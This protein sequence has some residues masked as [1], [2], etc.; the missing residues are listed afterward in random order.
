LVALAH[1]AR[2]LR[3]RED[4]IPTRR[5]LDLVLVADYFP[6]FDHLGAH[7]KQVIW[8]EPSVGGLFSSHE[9]GG[10]IKSLKLDPIDVAIAIRVAGSHGLHHFEHCLALGLVAFAHDRGE[11]GIGE[12]EIPASEA[13]DLSYSA[14]H[15]PHVDHFGAQLQEVRSLEVAP[16]CLLGREQ[17]VR[18]VKPLEFDPVNHAVS[19]RVQSPHGLHH[20][21]H[22]LALGLVAFAHDRGELGIGENEIPA[23]DSLDLAPEA[24][25]FPHAFH[26]G[27]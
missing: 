15:L 25:D 17:I 7:G 12:N 3:I 16:N 26:L 19:I 10:Q 13:L 5:S 24:D 9:D 4:E 18:Q 1:D 27:A 8:G 23:L 21:E 6:H 22:C 2:K 20:F 11:L 14:N